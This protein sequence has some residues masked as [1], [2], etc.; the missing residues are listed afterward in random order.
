MNRVGSLIRDTAMAGSA[1]GA[2]LLSVPACAQGPAVQDYDIS[3]QDL[4]SALSTLANA[5]GLQLAANGDLIAGR[6]SGP[7][8]GHFSPQEALDAALAGTGLIAMISGDTIIIRGRSSVAANGAGAG[9]S[10]AQNV[11]A[12]TTSESEITVTGTRIKGAPP[13]FPVTTLTRD[14]IQ[15]RGES[16]L[17]EVIRSLP[18]NFSGGQNPGVGFGAVGSE[19]VTS[20]SALNLRG[21]GSDA[22]L[23]LL[24]GHRL[25]YDS[26]NQS[27]DISA[28][29]VAAIERLEIV[30]DGASALYGS[31]AVGGVANVILRRDFSG[32]DTRIR[33]GSTTEGGGLQ[34]EYSLVGGSRWS[35]GGFIATADV[36]KVSAILAGDRA[37]TSIIPSDTTLDPSQRVQSFVL[38]GHQAL[39]RAVTFFA[40]SFY[41]HRTSFT[42]YSYAFPNVL[43]YGSTFH[44]DLKSWSIAPKASIRIGSAWQ[45]DLQGVHAEDKVATNTNYFY[46]GENIGLYPVDYS[47][48][49]DSIEGSVEGPLYQLPAGAIR[50]AAGGGY[51]SVGLRGVQQVINGGALASDTEF[52]GHRHTAYGYGELFVPIFGPANARSGFQRLD[53]TFAGRFEHDAETGS[54]FTPRI[55]INYEPTAD[56]GFEGSW[57]RSFKEPTIYQ[58]ASPTFAALGQASSYATGYP[59]NATIIVRSGA[60]PD[61]KPER[62][63]TLSGTFKLHP[64]RIPGLHV[65]LSYFNI[66]YRNRI[67][68]PISSI[69]GAL[70]NPL[71]AD[72]ITLDPLASAL[73]PIVSSASGGLENIS[74]QAYDPANVVAIIDNRYRNLSRYT[75][76]GVDIAISAIVHLPDGA[77]LAPNALAS[78]LKSSRV[79]LAGE[80]AVQ[81]A[82]TIYNPPHWRARLDAPWTKGSVTIAPAMNLIGGVTDTTTTNDAHVRGMTTFDLTLRYVASDQARIKGLEV[83]LS[84]L[85]IANRMPGRISVPASYYPAF[86]STNYSAQGRYV[87]LT[88]GKRW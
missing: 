31:D 86:D 66:H 71:Y 63:R 40:D 26:A 37:I 52:Q 82:G 81:A 32:L 27:I 34:Q 4:G 78:Y 33:V 24:D 88:V 74:G 46:L 84:V 42:S 38:S 57:G 17:G 83:A 65:D 14:Q 22:T 7:V 62:A 41:T 70:D 45:A 55:G 68:A 49:L 44:T 21:L 11:E 59:A 76:S 18:Q 58:Q 56:F 16:D 67:L 51:R 25:A 35:T 9:R 80:D 43:A 29:P 47:N 48:R 2:L 13:T 75:A 73:D 36:S 87:G 8:H 12:N 23:T 6:K 77:T 19:N 39:G 60:N 72:F 1:A 30:P 64:A 3:T 61:L 79:S 5:S 85:N 54:V 20:G 15:V 10:G 28:I 69:A 50:L 53:L